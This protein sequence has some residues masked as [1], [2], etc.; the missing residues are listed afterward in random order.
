M[1]KLMDNP[2]F[3]KIIALLLAL[4][5]YSSVPQ[6]GTK[7]TGVNVPGETS[8]ATIKAM[9][10]KVYYDTENLVVS[11]IP[12][13]VDVNIK[14][15]MTL[16]ESANALKN[17][18]VY[19]DLTKAKIG[20]Q[21]V[22]FK[23]RNLSDKLQPA[24]TPASVTVHIQ[25]KVTKEFKVDAE[26]KKS[27]LEAGYTSG[28][29]IMEPGKVKITGAR[30]VIDQIAYVK[31]LVD[32]KTHLK[33]TYTTDAPIQVLDAQLNKLNVTVDPGSVKVTIPIKNT[34][35]T[36]P[37][38]I[39]QKG[40]PPAGITIN[41][42]SLDTTEAMITGSDDLLKNTA[43]VRVEVDTSKIT[44]NTTLTLPVI[45]P[46]GTTSV[47]PETVQATVTVKKTVDK[48]ISGVPIQ[49]RGLQGQYKAVINDPAGQAV[50]L[51]VSG[52]DTVVNGLSSNNF[53]AYIDLSN[54]PAGDHQVNIQVDG[55]PD[56]S[57][58]LDKIAAS[59]TINNA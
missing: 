20:N 43:S 22:Q 51:L 4:L 34:S 39:L 38:D 25:E 9:P 8:S 50:N 49:I 40:A 16:V 31:A 47:T 37:I 44:D 27:L 29:P 1:D 6:T 35:K 45:I 2:W 55:P 58:K 21:K 59:V 11:G 7:F 30:D 14:G 3:I 24:I 5:L 46:N 54:L 42:I 36:V 18:E 53:N 57:W 15:P 13:T 19:L 12:N 28:T 41:S 17:F 52:Q 32:G 33:A 48:T 26:F 10:V 23:V 56:V